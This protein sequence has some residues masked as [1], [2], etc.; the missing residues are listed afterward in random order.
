MRIKDAD[1]A[2]LKH[3]M[4]MKDGRYD[5]HKSVAAIL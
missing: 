1:L 3:L 2:I 4:Q 5:T